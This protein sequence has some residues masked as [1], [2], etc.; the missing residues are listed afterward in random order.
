MEVRGDLSP[1]ARLMRLVLL[2]AALAFAFLLGA[3]FGRFYSFHEFVYELP[4]SQNTLAS[5]RR[6]FNLQ[7]VYG[8][9]SQDLWVAL[10]LGHGRNGGYYVDVGSADGVEISNTYL[11]DRMGWKGVCIDP[12]PTNM[13][14]R[15]CQVFE[16]PVYSESGKKVQFRAA[17]LLGGIDSDLGRYKKSLSDEPLVDFVTATL[18]EILDKA[19][20][21]NWI[22]YMNIDVEG[23]EYDVLRGFSFDRYQVGSWTIEHNFETEKRELIRKLMESKGYVRV[24]SWEVDDWYVHRDLAKNYRTFL[25]YYSKEVAE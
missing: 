17:G 10:T 12:F 7:P 19:R 25:T 21:P 2:V 20:A 22:D 4:A 11:L 8:Q 14:K 9:F 23:A 3:R 15:T 6:L 13:Q 24:R 5:F 1:A 18:D 16:Q